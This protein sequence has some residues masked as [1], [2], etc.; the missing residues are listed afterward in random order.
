MKVLSLFDG[1]SCGMVALERA[2]IEVDTYYASEID[3]HAEG[4]SQYNY[5]EIV[6]LGDVNNYEHWNLPSIDLLIGG[7]PCQDLSIAKANREGLNGERSGLFWK[8]VECLKKFKPK[9]FLLENNNSMP[10]EAKDTISEILGVKPIMINSSLVSAQLRKRLYWTN[11]PGVEQPKDK[12]ILLADIIESG[13]V[14]REKALC[15]T[16]RYAGFSGGQDYYRHRYFGKS[17]GQAVFEGNATPEEHKRAYKKL[18]RYSG[19]EIDGTMRQMTHNECEKLQTLPIDYTKYEIINNELKETP[20]GA[21][22]EMIGNG[23]TVDVIAHIFK[24]LN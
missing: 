5:P 4:V 9:Y 11:I 1:I 14:D 8:Y 3:N 7:S 16:R 22:Y 17:F 15:L 13:T 12:G 18:G 19:I 24:H 20:K 10:K 23:W 2:G 6:R 21:R